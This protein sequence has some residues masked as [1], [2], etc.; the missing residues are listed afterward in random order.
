MVYLFRNPKTNE[1]R[2]IPQK[3]N[4]NHVYFADGV[5]WTR[6][7]TKPEAAIDVKIDPFSEKQ[8]I[9][10]TGKS[11]G[12]LGDLWDRSK[13]YSEKRAQKVGTVDPI[14]Q[15]VFDNWSKARGGKK[16]RDD[17]QR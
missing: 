17:P 13:E 16:H 4:D 7:W 12:T 14:K 6:E 15:K 1:I 10:R 11:K 3:M 8:Y 2:E 5:E 9:E